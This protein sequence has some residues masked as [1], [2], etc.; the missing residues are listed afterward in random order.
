MFSTHGTSFLRDSSADIIVGLGYGSFLEALGNLQ[1]YPV[2]SKRQKTQRTENPD[3]SFGASGVGQTDV[4]GVLT[5][6][7]GLEVDDL[8]TLDSS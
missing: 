3:C 4:P 6:A 2:L 7:C 5:G 1:R 8:K